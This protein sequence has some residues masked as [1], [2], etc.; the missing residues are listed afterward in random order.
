MDVFVCEQ[1]QPLS[2]SSTKQDKVFSLTWPPC[3]LLVLS[4]SLPLKWRGGI[5]TSEMNWMLERRAVKGGKEKMGT[6]AP[7]HFFHPLSYYRTPQGRSIRERESEKKWSWGEN[8]SNVKKITQSKKIK[9]STTHWLEQSLYEVF[10]NPCKYGK[11][12]VTSEALTWFH[13]VF[14]LITVPLETP[15]LSLIWIH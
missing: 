10:F 8:F 7:V 6:G 4:L 11:D 12:K 3:E 9:Y 1:M 2:S 14:F 15:L 5:I 13:Q